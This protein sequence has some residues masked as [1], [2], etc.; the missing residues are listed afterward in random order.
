ML[1]PVTCFTCGIPIGD[2][3]DLFRLLRARRVR[4]VLAKT[5]TSARLAVADSSLQVDCSD[6][7][8]RL[9][10]KRDCC[11]MHLATAMVFSDYF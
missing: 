3:E 4:E 11:R 5:G 1:T 6:I 8:D 10:V 7:M 2:K 9:C